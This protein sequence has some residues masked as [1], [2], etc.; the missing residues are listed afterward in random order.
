[1]QVDA[2]C[3]NF[4]NQQDKHNITDPDHIHGRKENILRY[5][6]LLLAKK[7]NQF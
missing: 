1:M 3:R 5:Y 6:N 4:L 7:F 2:G